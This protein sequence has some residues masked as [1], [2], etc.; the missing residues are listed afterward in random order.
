[1]PEGAGGVVQDGGLS[2]GASEFCFCFIRRVMV[3]VFFFFQLLPE[4]VHVFGHE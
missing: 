3:R 1:M 2:P 4:S